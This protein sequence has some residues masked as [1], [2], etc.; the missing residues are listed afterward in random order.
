MSICLHCGDCCNRMSPLN[1]GK[2]PKVEQV[3]DFYFC[4]GYESR[5]NECVVH[6]FCSNV[7]PIG[8]SILK[9]SNDDVDTIKSRVINGRDKRKEL[10][11]GV[12]LN[13][14]CR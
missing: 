6:G 4:G 14:F 3:D 10:F 13:E 12:I 9:I 1:G 5:P 11:E 8:L 2:C 7:C